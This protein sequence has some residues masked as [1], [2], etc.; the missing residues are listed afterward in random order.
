MNTPVLLLIFNR[1]DLTQRVFERIREAEPQA[2]FIA[3]DGPRK[4]RPED[5]ALCQEARSIIDRVDWG[6]EV[7]TLFR[8]ENLGC[9]KAVSSAITWFFEHVEEG[10][11]LE[12]DCVPDPS[13]FRYCAELL[14]RYRDDERIMAISGDN[15]Q[16][17]GFDPGA[18][19][20]FSIYNHCWGWASWRRAW[21]HYDGEI[22]QWP[23]LRGSG[24]L[25]G[26]LGSKPAAEYWRRIFDRVHA[27]QVDSWAYPWTFSCW[28]QHGLT[29]LPAV[30]LVTNIGFDDRATH[31]VSDQNGL[32]KRPTKRLRLPLMHPDSLTVNYS[33]D[34]STKRA[35]DSCRHRVIKDKIYR[36][37]SNF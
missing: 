13:F 27:N 16:P 1:P 37:L 32:S 8:D 3:A 23:S 2:L 26:W 35:F 5:I 31:T 21:R 25:E 11:I 9:K 36:W 6:C 15:F 34:E 10:I 17:P 28:S 22:K 20:Y 33:A 30:N 18:S 29:I 19:Y 4:D 12:D 7:K 14:E 24:W